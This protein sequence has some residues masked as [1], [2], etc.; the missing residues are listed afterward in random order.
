LAIVQPQTVVKWHRQRFR[1]YWRWRSRKKPGRP[2]IDAEVRNLI[3]RECLDHLIVLNEDHLRR[4]LSESFTHYYEARAHLSLDRNS[5]TP[6]P[7]CPPAQGKI[8]AKAYLGGL[9]QC[10]MRAA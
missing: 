4:T 10:Y 1:L 6:R 7:V 2:K 5:P 3:C 8:V 9:H